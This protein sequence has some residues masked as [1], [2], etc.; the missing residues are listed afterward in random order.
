MIVDRLPL[1]H[2]SVEAMTGVSR[3]LAKAQHPVAQLERR[4]HDETGTGRAY[5]VAAAAAAL[6]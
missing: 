2:H 3:Q 6:R 5:S 4:L 1:P